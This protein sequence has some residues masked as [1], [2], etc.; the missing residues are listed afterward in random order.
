[1]TEAQASSNVPSNGN[2]SANKPCVSA[3]NNETTNNNNNDSSNNNNGTNDEEKISFKGKKTE[4]LKPSNSSY[5]LYRSTSAEEAVKFKPKKIDDNEAKKLEN[6]ATVGSA[7]NTGATME[8][9]DY[10]KWVK[11]KLTEYLKNIKFNK[12][13]LNEIKIDDVNKM[14]CDASIIFV[15]GKLRAGYDI[16]FDI[17]YKGKYFKNNKKIEVE[18]SI[19][20]NEICDSEDMDDW[21][22]IVKPKKSNSTGKKVAS[23]I[24][25]DKKVVYDVVNKMLDE[26]KQKTKK[27]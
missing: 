18:G 20:M 25:S 6:K 5:Y 19:I 7:W 12:S 8:E 17:K 26:F 16:H 21:E 2:S 24:K 22:F 15:R 1:M 13:E 3:P 4:E 9:Y 27:Q 23:L 14:E 11:D 10:S